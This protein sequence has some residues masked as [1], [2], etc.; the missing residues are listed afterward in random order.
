MSLRTRF[1]FVPAAVLGAVL[2]A[3]PAVAGSETIPVVEGVA[4]SGEGIYKVPPHWAPEHTELAQPGT[5]TFKNTSSTVPHGIVWASSQVPACEGSVPVGTFRTS[6][7]GT[8]TFT[9]AGEYTFYCAYH[10]RSMHG[11]VSVSPGGQV[12]SSTTGTPPPPT[13]SS[14]SPPAPATTPA[15]SAAPALAGAASSAVK[16]SYARAGGSLAGSVDVGAGGAGG[17]L[18]VLALARSAS[19]ARARGQVRIGLYTRAALP[20]GVVRFHVVLSARAR[21]ALRRHG[22][23]RVSVRVT[24]TPVQG[25]SV[26]VTRALTLRG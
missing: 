9:K 19:L 21:Q 11:V 17:R 26:V 1:A 5:I 2:A 3:L 8:C 14:S 10:G 24:L 23:L 12:T 13:T 15:P 20:A 18:Q 16:V 6:W 4:E 22:R 25:P 7:S